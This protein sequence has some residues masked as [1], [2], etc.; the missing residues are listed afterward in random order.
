[1]RLHQIPEQ[2]YPQIQHK[3]FFESFYFSNEE[4]YL[5]VDFD[6]DILPEDRATLPKYNSDVCNISGNITEDVFHVLKDTFT[7]DC[8]RTLTFQTHSEASELPTDQPS[9]LPASATDQ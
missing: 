6:M 3:F 8:M 2:F 9:E 4:A 5:K 1:M 7:K